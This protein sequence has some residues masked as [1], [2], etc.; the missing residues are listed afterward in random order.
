MRIL[1]VFAPGGT[2]AATVIGD[3]RGADTLSAVARSAAG[4]GRWTGASA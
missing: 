4:A 2:V 3:V 1:T